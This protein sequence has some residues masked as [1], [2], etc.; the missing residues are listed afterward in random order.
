M[1]VPALVSFPD[2]LWRVHKF[3]YG[4]LN[5]PQRS[6]TPDLAW[7]RFDI[8]GWAVVY[9]ATSR[10]G[11][12]LEALSYAETSPLELD[13]LFDDDD[14]ESVSTQWE[15]LGHMAPGRIARQWR[16]VR[17]ITR[18]SPRQP[19]TGVV[20]DLLDSATISFLRATAESWAPGQFRENPRSIDVSSL[21]GNDRVFTTQVAWWLSRTT[22]PSGELPIGLR[23]SSRHGQE[24]GCYALWVDLDRFGP[25]EDVVDAVATEYEAGRDT[26]IDANDRDLRA[27]ASL[28]D[29]KVF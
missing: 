23:Y 18:I 24:V 21:T 9:G 2:G 14:A 15:D 26:V 12:F 5:P 7:S 6:G 22:L 28:L 29:L 4:P 13:E 17:R 1:K 20:I 10:Q 3:E 25:A 8:P 11:A 16:D 27:A 19:S